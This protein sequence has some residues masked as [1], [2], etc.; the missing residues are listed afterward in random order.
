MEKSKRKPIDLSKSKPMETR[1]TR[2]GA[3][4]ISIINTKGNGRRIKLSQALMEKLGNPREIQFRILDNKFILG[5]NLDENEKSFRFSKTAEGTIY[6]SAIVNSMT[7]VLELDFTNVTSVTLTN[8]RVRK[9]S[10]F[11]DEI[12]R[13][14]IV[15]RNE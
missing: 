10:F 5:C 6:S 4:S 8:I 3:I 9:A 15:K 13:V 7:E 12:K 14:A 11:D 2:R 1:D